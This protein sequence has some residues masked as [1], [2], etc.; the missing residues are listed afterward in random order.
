MNVNSSL[1]QQQRYRPPPLPLN[2]RAGL[3]SG[4]RTAR[5]SAASTATPDPLSQLQQAQNEYLHQLQLQ[6]QHQS[7]MLLLQQQQAEANAALLAMQQGARVGGGRGARI[8]SSSAE[9]TRSV[10]QAQ[11]QYL[12]GPRSAFAGGSFLVSEEERAAA[13]INPLVASALARRKRQSLNADALSAMQAQ[14]PPT[15]GV[16]HRRQSSVET[17]STNLS[18]HTSSPSST[19]ARTPPATTDPPAL[20]LSQPGEAYP[21]TSGSEADDDAGSTSSIKSKPKAR[22]YSVHTSADLRSSHPGSNASSSPDL[23]LDDPATN[24][25]TSPSSGRRSHVNDLTLAL[26]G[27]K[28]RPAALEAT[29]GLG[30][31]SVG[32]GFG[33]R[34]QQQHLGR[35]VSDTTPL[36][37]F[38]STFTP[39]PPSPYITSP[40]F[41]ALQRTLSPTL[42]AFSPQMHA[43]SPSMST[44][45]PSLGSDNYQSSKPAPISGTASAIRQPR[46]PAAE[47]AG[48]FSS[49]LRKR[50][51]A[52][53]MG[54]R[55]GRTAT[56]G[57]TLVGEVMGLGVEGVDAT[58]L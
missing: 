11:Q 49:R 2:D 12:D 9:P 28:Q 54:S 16:L 33:D 38:A 8:R 30:S 1:Q 14:S 26:S 31:P 42:G 3:L 55:M 46:G 50:A 44:S 21:S 24:V 7:Q 43:F 4:L 41:D 19:A 20:I 45:S 56:G 27:R 57:D 22:R 58:G 17:S 18:R 52:T 40:R 29:V 13:S 35:S 25:H 6:I 37:P 36:S 53:L 39:L 47:L 10:T 34:S 32:A 48:N 23:A 15:H 51:V 5:G